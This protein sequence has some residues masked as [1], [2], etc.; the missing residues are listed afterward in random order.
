MFY[1]GNERAGKNG[2]GRVK[3]WQVNDVFLNRNAAALNGRA[4]P[5]SRLQSGPAAGPASANQIRNILINSARG[6]KHAAEMKDACF[7]F[8]FFNPFLIVFFFSSGS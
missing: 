1:E 6:A 5:N 4:A 7:I 8:F 2:L 3:A